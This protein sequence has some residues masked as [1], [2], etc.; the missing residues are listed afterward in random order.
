MCVYIYVYIY[1]CICICIYIYICIHFGLKVLVRMGTLGPTYLI[2]GYLDPLGSAA[3]KAAR[4]K[5]SM[6]LSPK[7]IVAMSFGTLMFYV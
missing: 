2:Y 7:T 5:D 6:Q 3:R 4:H 1:V